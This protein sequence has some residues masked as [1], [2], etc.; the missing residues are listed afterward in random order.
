M[1]IRVRTTAGVDDYGHFLRLAG[2]YS[3]LTKDQELALGRQVRAWLDAPNPSPEVAQAGRQAK[4]TLIQCNLRLVASIAQKHRYRG[5]EMIDLVQEGVV[6]LNR[7]V[8]KYQPAKGHKFSTYAYAWIRQAVSR[9]VDEKSRTIRL[10]NHVC[11][12]ITM[13]KF[14]SAQYQQEHGHYPTRIQVAEYL[15]AK[16]KL[17]GPLDK[18]LEQFALYLTMARGV[19]SINYVSMTVER[20]VTIEERLV[21]PLPRPETIAAEDAKI[22]L[23][24]ELMAKLSGPEQEVLALRYGLNQPSPW[25]MDA[26]ADHMGVATRTV[27]RLHKSALTTLRQ[28]IERSDAIELLR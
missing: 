15:I 28:W 10:P 3:L 5:V 11:E 7:A 12:A 18:A 14:W 25:Q 6:G 13:A 24:T 21:C 1:Q 4:D 27:R 22:E 8:E 2:R 20:E 9:A 17:N 23:L 19:G 16:K 26:I